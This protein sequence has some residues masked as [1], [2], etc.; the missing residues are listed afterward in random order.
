[1]TEQPYIQPLWSIT[2]RN[3]ETDERVIVI[4]RAEAKQQA[5]DAAAWQLSGG[6][7]GVEKAERGEGLPLEAG[8]KAGFAAGREKGHN[9][10]GRQL[11]AARSALW[12]IAKTLDDNELRAYALE[13]YERTA[14]TTEL[15]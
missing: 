7:W 3:S 10:V 4:A 6:P 14:F 1:M 12:A 15:K 5:I 8:A 11:S 9:E 13:A 2:F